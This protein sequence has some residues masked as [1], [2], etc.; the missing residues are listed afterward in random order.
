CSR[1]FLAS[2]NRALPNLPTP[3]PSGLG[4]T[5]IDPNQRAF[6]DSKAL[7][8]SPMKTLKYRWETDG[9]PYNL[10]LVHVEGTNGQ[11]YSFGDGSERVPMDV[12]SF[13]I[14]TVTVTQ[15]LWTHVMGPDT[16]PALHRGELLPVENISWDQ[17]TQPFGFLDRINESAVHTELL[18]QVPAG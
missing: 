16:N 6:L 3:R 15:V 7:K 2:R 10:E 1:Y 11:P 17:L 14:A 18:A 13:Y 4:R 9:S 5:M 8:V 12:K